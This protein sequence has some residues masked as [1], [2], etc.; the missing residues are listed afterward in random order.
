MIKTFKNKSTNFYFYQSKNRPKC[1]GLDKFS[2]IAQKLILTRKCFEASFYNNITYEE[3]C[4]IFNKENY[5]LKILIL[6]KSKNF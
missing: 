4:E 2:I 3:F 5:L 6:K 1:K